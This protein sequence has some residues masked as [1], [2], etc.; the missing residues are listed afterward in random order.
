VGLFRFRPGCLPAL[1]A[2]VGEN[3]DP[4]P[5]LETAASLQF[6]ARWERE[7]CIQGEI[8]HENPGRNLEAVIGDPPGRVNSI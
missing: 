1:P 7:D 4:A 5:Q 2:A 6:R 3:A 8:G